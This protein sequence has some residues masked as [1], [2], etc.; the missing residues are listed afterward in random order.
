M[1]RPR[2]ATVLGTLTGLTLLTIAMLIIPACAGM[3]SYLSLGMHFTTTPP[4]PAPTVI[5]VPTPIATPTAAA[6]SPMP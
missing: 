5:A 3:P 1:K 2:T 4:P 6:A